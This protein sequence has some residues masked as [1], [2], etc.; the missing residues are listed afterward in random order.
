MQTSPTLTPPA[1]N[2]RLK[3]RGSTYKKKKIAISV[4]CKLQED[5]V[6]SVSHWLRS[7]LSM[8]LICDESQSLIIY[9]ICYVIIISD[10]WYKLSFFNCST[11]YL[12]VFPDDRNPSF[13]IYTGNYLKYFIDTYSTIFRMIHLQSHIYYLYCLYLDGWISSVTFFLNSLLNH[14]NM[15]VWYIAYTC[16]IFH[17]ALFNDLG[18]KITHLM[19]VLRSSQSVYP[20][21]QKYLTW[22]SS[23]WCAASHTLLANTQDSMRAE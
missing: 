22:L 6:S 23:D 21:L 19:P 17:G 15:H 10:Y 12:T 11:Q 13:M 2:R 16:K 9:N 5:L 7:S 3:S 14:F 1:P 8:G 4:G 20:A 18:N